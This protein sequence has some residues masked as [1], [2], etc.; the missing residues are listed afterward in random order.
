MARGHCF[1]CDVTV[2]DTTAASYQAATSTVAGSAIES[3]AVR[4]K[5]KLELF[6]RYYFFPI[7]FASHGPL[8][9]K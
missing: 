1:A 4:K 6:N 8:S 2:A 3:V 9:N 5:A 7:A